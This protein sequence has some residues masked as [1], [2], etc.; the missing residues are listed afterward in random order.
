MGTGSGS[1]LEKYR[2]D[3][4]LTVILVPSRLAPVVAVQAWVGVGSIDEPPSRA[5]IAHVFEHMLFKGTKRR[6][7][8]SI[9][10][11][12]EGAGGAINAWTGFH[13]TVFHVVLAGRDLDIGLDV[14]AD[15]LQESTFDAD[16]LAREREVVVEEILQ[17]RDSPMRNAVQ[18]LLST[19]LVEHPYRRPITGDEASVRALRRSHMLSFYQRWYVANNVTLVIVGDFD[20]RRAKRRVSRYFGQMRYR[21]IRRRRHRE[22]EQ[23]RARAAVT[24]QEVRESYI[25]LGFPTPT[26]GSSD[27]PALDVAA[28]T[29]GQGESSRLWRRVQRDRGLVTGVHAQMQ[30]LRERGMLMVSAVTSPDKLYDAVEA[31]AE[32]SFEMTETL[33]SRADIERGQRAIEAERVYQRETVQGMA[34][35]YGYYHAHVGDSAFESEYLNRILALDAEDVRAVA[36][37]HMRP[38]RVTVAAV[39]PPAHIGRGGRH[40]AARKLLGRVRKSA[41]SVARKRGTKTGRTRIAQR[42]ERD[43]KPTTAVLNNGVRV[44]IRRDT[45]VP[46]V[47][48]RAVWQGGVRRETEATSGVS[49]ALAR[50][51]VRGCA[52]MDAE[53]I[54]TRLDELAGSLS[55]FSGRD[56]FGLRASWLSKHWDA[57]LEMFANCVIR[58]D[59]DDNELERERRR[60]LDELEARK[61]SPNYNVFRLFIETL[62]RRHP[63][64][65]PV[66]GDT[67]N[68]AG[69]TRRKLSLFYRRHYPLSAL[70]LVIVGDVSPTRVLERVRRLFD[71]ER[72]A[73]TATDKRAAPRVPVPRFGDR[74][75]NSREVY[76][77]MDRNQAHL[78]IGFPGTTLDHPDRFALAVLETVLGGQGGRLFGELRDRQALVYQVSAMARESI[79]PGYFAVY[80]ACSP[81][82]LPAAVA[83]VRRQLQAVIDHSVTDEELQRAK[84]YL[85]GTHEISL[86]RRSAVASALAFHEAYGLG[87]EQVERYADS[88]RAVTAADVQR[89]ATSYLDWSLAVTATVKPRDASPA[90]EKRIRGV[91]KRVP[92]TKRKRKATSR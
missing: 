29:L 2:L 34:R 84:R 37:S 22:P 27:L 53:A 64:R 49:H 52:G 21:P 11:E 35:T 14:L 33:P 17:S 28:M 47:A 4:G 8:G 62:Y 45:S 87:Y 69:F 92:R 9:A 72:N 19:A 7:I 67:E 32:E 46:V 54:A 78:V 30:A 31:I 15:A 75:A 61:D 51:L 56:S 10:R 43:V 79:D 25:V 86:Q 63:Y 73:G 88:M 6:G 57:G 36:R 38:E 58:P 74:S 59:F 91:N 24:T 44:L 23:T 3:N 39:V 82:K 85:I 71:T 68:V 77:F 66:A 76:R 50:M 81:D 80:L 18:L 90:A 42:R 5:G 55:G 40:T 70:T 16:E 20:K 26:L 48:M 12:I 13:S 41:M 1:C 60:I 89:V 65:L 83:G